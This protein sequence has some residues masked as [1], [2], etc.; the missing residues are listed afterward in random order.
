MIPIYAST[1]LL[2]LFAYL[3]L[4]H[5]LYSIFIANLMRCCVSFL[6]FSSSIQIFETSLS[7]NSCISSCLLSGWRVAI[8]YCPRYCVVGAFFF[9]IF[10]GLVVARIV[11][12]YNWVALSFL[13]PFH[14]IPSLSLHLLA[15]GNKFKKPDIYRHVT[16][17]AIEVWRL[18]T[19]RLYRCNKSKK[20][21]AWTRSTVYSIIDTLRCG[22]IY[23][24][25]YRALP[26]SQ[27]ALRFS[28]WL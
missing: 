21:Y 2:T 22:A 9:R 17:V 11:L 25:Q 20:M 5:A 23:L 3:L 6:S 12:A 19:R 4:F 8:L 13:L 15:I 1:H 28:G 16:Y 7:T 24:W 26:L 10:T 14:W 18:Y 27:L